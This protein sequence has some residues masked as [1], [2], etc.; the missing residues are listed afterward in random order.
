MAEKKTK[1]D[2]EDRSYSI[3]RTEGRNEIEALNLRELWDN[4]NISLNIT[5]M[6][7]M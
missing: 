2:P 5:V 1:P 4:S 7:I 3:Q 6:V